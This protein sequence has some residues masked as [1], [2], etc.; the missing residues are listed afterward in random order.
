MDRTQSQKSDSAMDI[1]NI[2]PSPLS[3]IEREHFTMQQRK[4][5]DGKVLNGKEKGEQQEYQS[6]H[7]KNPS[8]SGAVT[9]AEAT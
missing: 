7:H 8:L 6:L 4:L 3:S 1:D 5:A 2:T 9:P